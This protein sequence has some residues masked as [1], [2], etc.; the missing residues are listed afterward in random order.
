MKWGFKMWTVAES[1][2]GYV[3]GYDIYTGRRVAPSHQDMT[4]SRGLQPAEPED[5]A[6]LWCCHH[7]ELGDW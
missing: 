4:L 7:L 6:R 3:S 1:G 5:P 2:I